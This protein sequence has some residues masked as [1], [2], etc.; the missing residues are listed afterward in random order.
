MYRKPRSGTLRQQRQHECGRGSDEHLLTDAESGPQDSV[1]TSLSVTRGNEA[2]VRSD[3]EQPAREAVTRAAA[4]HIHMCNTQ[5]VESAKHD[6]RRDVQ[7]RPQRARVGSAV[8]EGLLVQAC[9]VP[10]PAE[11]ARHVAQL[12]AREPPLGDSLDDLGGPPLKKKKWCNM[13]TRVCT[14]GL[15]LPPA[16]SC[17]SITIPLYWSVL[18]ERGSI[19]CHLLSIHMSWCQSA[20]VPY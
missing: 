11:R 18:G 5:C 2:P 1:L 17:L 16:C 6:A 13:Q 9:A 19:W 15:L 14:A 3:E 8:R 4:W 10:G 7:T 20:R 12:V